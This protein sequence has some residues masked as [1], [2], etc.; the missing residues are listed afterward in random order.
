[1]TTN[2]F[3][4]FG[5]LMSRALDR[6][7]AVMHEPPEAYGHETC[8]QKTIPYTDREAIAA[9]LAEATEAE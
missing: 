5:T 4:P 9:R 1:M 2:T 8:E 6:L 3:T 7:D